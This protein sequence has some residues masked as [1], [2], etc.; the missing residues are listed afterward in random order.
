[1]DSS[2]RLFVRQLTRVVVAALVPVVLIA[3]WSIPY[4][5][6]GHPGEARS[7]GMATPRHMT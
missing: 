2:L 1:M 5:L 6:G 3:F 4:S 7:V